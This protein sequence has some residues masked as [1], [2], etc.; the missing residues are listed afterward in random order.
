[1]DS[2]SEGILVLGTNGRAV[3]A[4]SAGL[5]LLGTTREQLL[6]REQLEFIAKEDRA[7]AR[8]RFDRCLEGESCRCEYRLVRPDGGIV[9]AAIWASQCFDDAGVPIGLI[10]H[11]KDMTQQRSTEA[12]LVQAEDRL[13]L[14]IDAAQLGT[15][16][17]DLP[18]THGKFYWN[19]TVR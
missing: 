4:N 2:A 7:A 3:Y 19:K 14:A 13:R 15:F 17:C 1:A 8:A 10:C 12:A 5:A 9:W 18:L 6:G 11:L 16:N